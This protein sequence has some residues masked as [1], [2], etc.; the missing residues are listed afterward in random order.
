[1]ILALREVDEYDWD[2][3]EGEEEEEEEWQLEE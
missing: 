2:N 1:M 3:A